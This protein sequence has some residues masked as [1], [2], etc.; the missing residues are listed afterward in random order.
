MNDGAM[1]SCAL[2]PDGFPEHAARWHPATEVVTARPGRVD[3]R[4]GYAA[5]RGFA[6][7]EAIVGARPQV[8]LAAVGRTDPKWGVR[9]PKMPVAAT[10]KV[11]KLRLRSQ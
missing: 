5:L 8:S 4:I 11:D 9:L 10:G 7:I 2:T 1:Q 6:H 3:S